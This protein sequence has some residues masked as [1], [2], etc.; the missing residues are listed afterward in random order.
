M[1]EYQNVFSARSGF[2]LAEN[3]YSPEERNRQNHTPERPVPPM[4]RWSDMVFVQWQEQCDREPSCSLGDVRLILR[5]HIVYPPSF[6][7]AIAALR[8]RGFN[9]I[10]QFGSREVFRPGDDDEG[11]YA[12]LGEAHGA[13]AAYFLIQHK[14]QL[15][16]RGITSFTVWANSAGHSTQTSWSRDADPYLFVMAEVESMG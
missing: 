12:I 6:D 10:P 15:G 11:F 7:I 4:A 13:G 14:G 1:G 2:I 8:R 16:L 5:H 9:T 3:N